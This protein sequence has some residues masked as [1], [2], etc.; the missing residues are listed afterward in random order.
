M[1]LKNLQSQNSS[2]P[3]GKKPDE[4]MKMNKGIIDYEL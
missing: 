2:F 1:Y 3:E 4:K